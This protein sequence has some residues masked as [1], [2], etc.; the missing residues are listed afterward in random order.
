MTS[1]A[2]ML[3]GPRGG[4]FRVSPDVTAAEVK[5]QAA[6]A[7]LHYARVDL[8][9]ARSREGLLRALGKALQFPEWYGQ[10]WD[11]LADCLAD[12][13]W[14]PAQ[15]WVLLLDGAGAS[16]ADG[17]RGPLPTAVEVLRDAAA[18]WAEEGRP[19]VAVVRGNSRSRK[20]SGRRR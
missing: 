17:D 4:V 6:A 13:S 12:L 16:G 2:R 11:A 15:G 20:A 19:F 7:G 1:L 9:R 3:A 8:S 5:R 14:L 18:S 10:N